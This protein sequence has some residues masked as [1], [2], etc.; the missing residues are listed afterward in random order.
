M[1]NETKLEKDVQSGQVNQSEDDTLV[2][3]ANFESKSE[4]LAED[5]ELQ[6]NKIHILHCGPPSLPSK[7]FNTM[8]G[9]EPPGGTTVIKT[10]QTMINYKCENDVNNLVSDWLKLG[11]LM[12]RGK[13]E[14]VRK[15]LSS[16]VFIN[17]DKPPSSGLRPILQYAK[18]N[19]VE[20]RQCV[21]AIIDCRAN[22]NVSCHPGIPLI[23]HHCEHMEMIRLLIGNGA[24]VDQVDGSKRN[25]HQY[26][27]HEINRVNYSLT[28]HDDG[29]STTEE[30]NE[31]IQSLKNYKETEKY[32]YLLLVCR[33]RRLE[34]C[35]L[36]GEKLFE[37]VIGI[38]N[39]YLIQPDYAN[40]PIIRTDPFVQNLLETHLF[41]QANF[42]S[43][44]SMSQ[45][46]KRF[47]SD[48][49]RPGDEFLD[50]FPTSSKPK[51]RS[52]HNKQYGVASHK[53]RKGLH[54]SN[55]APAPKR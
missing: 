41:R 15:F 17:L 3:V 44:Q 40:A 5:D 45:A 48:T 19:D 2:T 35:L 11:E 14:P 37:N 6:P 22:V 34:Q 43:E 25:I 16:H 39:S 29:Y 18:G 49:V 52:R 30:K 4:N 13:Y 27:R 10:Q 9:R 54:P 21:Q 36:D 20:S 26:I 32:I 7:G 50:F 12:S 55:P 53:P 24:E 42:I 46:S 1:S 23:F 31:Q 28:H 38:V 8:L 33:Q 47:R 51:K